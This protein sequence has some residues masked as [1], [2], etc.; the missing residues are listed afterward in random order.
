[1]KRIIFITLGLICVA[2]GGAGMIL[3]LLPTTPFLLLA[4]WLF[5]RSS[6][7]LAR[8]LLTNRFCGKYLADYRSGRGIPL[9][10]KVIVI[11]LLWITIGYSTL[12]VLTNIWLRL[13]LWMIAVVVTYHI[14]TFK[15]YKKE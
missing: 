14:T 9:R 13:L 2:L 5:M 6:P 4:L 1:M 15:T 11:S 7:E 10:V 12:F 3:P 8:W